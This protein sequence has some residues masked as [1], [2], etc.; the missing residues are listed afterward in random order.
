MLGN[1]VGSHTKLP[2]SFSNGQP[3]LILQYTPIYIESYVLLLWQLL[4]PTYGELE[5]A[6]GSNLVA[7]SSVE[8]LNSLELCGEEIKF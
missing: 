5:A 4:I 2:Q 7:I 8:L 1:N 6:N 3:S